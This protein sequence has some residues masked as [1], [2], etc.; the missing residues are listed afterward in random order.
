MRDLIGNSYGRSIN[1]NVDLIG[2][3]G[4][5]TIGGA[6]RGRGIEYLMYG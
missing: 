1:V 4:V 6:T 5:G 3:C 2:S